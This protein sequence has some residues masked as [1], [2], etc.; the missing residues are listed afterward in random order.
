M[1][2]RLL[3]SVAH[4]PTIRETSEETSPGG[5]G[6]ESP[7]SPSLD[8][9]VKSICQLAQPTPV[10]DKAT[11]RS[12]SNR[13]HRP[14]RITEKRPQA[15]SPGDSK[16]CS[17]GWQPTLPSAGT[18]DPL[19]WLFGESREQQANRRDNGTCPSDGY[20]SMHKQMDKNRK[21]LCE[22][23]MPERFL[24][25]QSQNRH[26]TS[27]LKSWTSRKLCPASA[28]AHSSRPCSILRSLYLHLPVIHEL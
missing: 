5:P 12:Q 18:H 4:M 19:D 2:S 17:G 20:W 27:N 10:L 9:Y 28:S 1:R 24:A 14:A 7:N 23:G 25:G 26:Q 6:Q 13:P 8:D 16:P 3:L 15:K 22:A 21:R 11:V